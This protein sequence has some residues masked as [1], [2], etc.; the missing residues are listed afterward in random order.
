MAATPHAK[1]MAGGRREITAV[2]G[3]VAPNAPRHGCGTQGRDPSPGCCGDAADRVA[4]TRGEGESA[5]LRVGCLKWW[6]SPFYLFICF[7]PLSAT[8][9]ARGEGGKERPWPPVCEGRGNGS[10]DG[11]RGRNERR[12]R[13]GRGRGCASP[14]H[15]LSAVGFVRP[16]GEARRHGGG[17]NGGKKEHLGEDGEGQGCAWGEGENLPV[18]LCR[19]S[20]LPAI[21]L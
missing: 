21:P 8:V 17:K 15:G 7:F 11:N 9:S 20:A 5:I 14:R 12:E 18:F 16:V 3:P 10:Q 1:T 4:R 19:P 13:G 2:V 6:L